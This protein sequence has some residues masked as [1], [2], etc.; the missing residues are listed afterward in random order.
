MMGNNFK[1]AGFGDVNAMV[2]KMV[3]SEDEQLKAM[4]EFIVKS[5][6]AP[7]LKG[8]D[9][10]GFARRYNG[11]NF[12]ANNYDNQLQHFFQIYTA[13]HLPDIKVRTAQAY[14]F[15]QGFLAG[16]IDGLIGSHTTAAVKAFQVK[17]GLAQ[18]GIIDDGL[19][20]KL[21]T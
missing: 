12:A 16:G 11:P 14:L 4:A 18:T 10:A 5:G 21:S 13:G 17:A 3:E 2:A 9:W 15:Y 6:M 20:D 7:S 19:L 1:N 8:R